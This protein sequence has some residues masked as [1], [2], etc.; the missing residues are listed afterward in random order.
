ML[1][2]VALTDINVNVYFPPIIPLEEPIIRVVPV[3]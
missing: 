3:S 2:R 1:S